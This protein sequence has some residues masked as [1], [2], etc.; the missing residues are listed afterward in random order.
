MPKRRRSVA[1]VQ[2]NAADDLEKNLAAVTLAVETAA[3]KGADLVVLPENFAYFGDAAGRR[4][5]AEPDGDLSAPVQGTVSGLARRLGVAIVA[6]GHPEKSPDP[7]RPYNTAQVFAA[8]GEPVGRYR[9]RHLFDV[10]LPDGSRYEESASTLPGDGLVVVDLDG[11]RCGLSICYDLRFPEQYRALVTMGAE[12]LLV[13]AAFTRTTGTAH[14]S[15]LLRARAIE[16][17]CWVVAPNQCGEHPG[18]RTTYGHSCV[19]DPW[20][21]VA[22]EAGDRPDTLHATLDLDRV[23]EVRANLP[24][25]THRRG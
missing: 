17:L 16:N 25:L 14:F 21:T 2:V 23:S 22:V 24:A 11:C 4:R 19:I 7:W 10:D 18:G 8:N 15:V 12:V 3:S 5:V 9:K 20:G 6:G 13:P 1:V